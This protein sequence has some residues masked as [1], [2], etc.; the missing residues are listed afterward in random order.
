MR[1]DRGVPLAL[2]TSLILTYLTGVEIIGYGIV[3][4]PF[5][6]LETIDIHSS[7]AV[8]TGILG[9]VLVVYSIRNTKRFNVRILSTLNILFIGLAGLSGYLYLDGKGFIY[10]FSMETFFVFSA[11]VTSVLAGM[12]MGVCKRET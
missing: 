8:L 2:L 11:I 12:L 3:P 10:V 4:F 5:S 6:Y 7:L 1:F 9:L